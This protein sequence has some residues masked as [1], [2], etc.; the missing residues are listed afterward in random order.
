MA[1]TE[2]PE[3]GFDERRLLRINVVEGFRPE[4]L[5]AIPGLTVVSQEGRDVALLFSS[6]AALA[7]VDQRLS[8][9]ARDGTVTRGDLLLAI[10]GFDSWRAE[11]R[12]GTALVQL[13]LSEPHESIVDVELWPLDSSRERVA[14]LVAF[15]AFLTLQ[16]MPILDRLNQ[17]SLLMFKLRVSA[18]QLTALLNY[19]DVRLVDLPAQFGFGIDVFQVDVNELPAVQPVP[20]GAP[21]ICVLD[22]GLAAAHP[23]L[24]PAVG[25]TANFVERGEATVDTDGHGTRVAGLALYGSITE[26][27][28]DGFQ[29][30]LRLFAGKVFGND[31][32]D[33]T[34]FVEKAVDEAVRYFHETYRCK[35]FCLAYGDRN[36]IYDGRHIRGLAY[37]LDRLSRDLDV[38]FVVPTGNL[39]DHDLPDDALEDY[40]GY[41]MQAAYRLLDPA[42]AVNAITVGGLAEFEQDH[43][44]QRYPERLETS[45]LA[46][47]NQPSPFT[48]VGP[49]IAGAIK[50]EFV[51]YGGNMAHHHLRRRRTTQRLGVISTSSRFAE[52]R[53]FDDAPGTSFAAPQVANLAATV[54]RYLPHASANTIRAVL[55]AHSR[56]PGEADTLLGENDAAKLALCG[57]GRIDS[58]HLFESADGAVTLLGEDAIATDHHHF[59]ELLLPDD[60]WHGR[61]RTRE[62]SVALAYCP[63]V[64]TTRIGYRAVKLSFNMV[65][66]DNL[67][68]VTGWFNS[69]RVEAARKLQE[70]STRVTVTAT[71]RSK[72]TLQCATWTFKAS[73]TRRLFIVVTRKD[74]IWYLHPEVPEP[75]ALA[76][77]FRDLENLEA[78]LYVQV[79]QR[80]QQREQARIRARG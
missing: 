45:P 65:E 32:R 76:V 68:Q 35:V 36:K 75:Y 21:G 62:V 1:A 37:T 20:E 33:Q 59:Y 78:N 31:G 63:D 44:A 23:L 22:T 64:K 4:D 80:V 42:T 67:E 72:G 38:L 18:Q 55:G 50:P 53:L 2:E 30:T 57:Y 74:E 43:D 48:R 39:L 27:M 25:D 6:E 3:P 5:E 16:R 69:N 58:R 26:C 14:M 34:R 17:P 79:R 60:F 41:L 40:P 15:E 46:R 7:L 9:L 10:R 70:A 12:M 49:S 54:L 28:R 52:G 71:A 47:R 51:A 61:R 13:G 29:P 24:G 8:T 73:G 77:T 19:R 66:A 56:M 11:D